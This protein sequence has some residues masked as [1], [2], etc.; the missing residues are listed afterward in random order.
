MHLSLW[1]AGLMTYCFVCPSSAF[2]GSVGVQ[3][4]SFMLTQ[5]EL[6]NCIGHKKH[7][8]SWKLRPTGGQSLVVVFG[9]KQP[10]LKSIPRVARTAA[11]NLERG[12]VEAEGVVQDALPGGQFLVTLATTDKK[13]L[14]ELSGKIR[15]NRIKV[16]P[17]D[18]VTVHLS[19][20]DLT[21]GR[22][23]RRITKPTNVDSGSDIE[24]D[25]P[26]DDD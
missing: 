21:K 9:K 6:N 8:S 2:I 13:V 5:S 14:C 26:I 3:E 11:E 17:G 25:L 7:Y 18:T 4:A 15:K 12:I 1:T 20:I 24:D 23:H 22:I 19:I 10:R 16:I